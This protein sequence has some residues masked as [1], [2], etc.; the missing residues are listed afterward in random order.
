MTWAELKGI[1]R[2]L[3]KNVE[4]L[5]LI[6]MMSHPGKDGVI[7]MTDIE[8][9]LVLIPVPP[10]P[11]LPLFKSS[12]TPTILSTLEASR[13]KSLLFNWRT[14][15]FANLGK[16]EQKRFSPMPASIISSDF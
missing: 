3:W 6:Q 14:K 16:C 10:P 13:T 12:I 7:I 8:Q 15:S 2:F 9:I 5:T 1:L 4:E 11:T